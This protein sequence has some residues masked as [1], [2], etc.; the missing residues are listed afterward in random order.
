MKRIILTVVVFIAAVTGYAQ[1]MS[2]GITVGSG[3]SRMSNSGQDVVH[4][5]SC[6][7]GGTFVYSTDTHWGFAADVKYSREGYKYTYPG[8]GSY[9]GQ[10]LDTRV[11]S[12]FIRIPIR[13]IYFFN[14][15]DKGVRPKIS[16]GPSVG[17]LTGGKIRV[18]D[19][20]TNLSK[21]PV[22]DQFNA[23]DLGIQGTIGVDFR[24]A[25]DVWLRTDIAYYQGFLKQNTYGSNNMMNMNLVLN[26]G[27]TV[28]IGK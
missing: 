13:A 23:V 20:K 21:T 4:K 24:L 17:F 10:T 14:T 8:T 15:Y 7:V 25:Q 1:H 26:L 11:S 6:N 18:E 19:D 16:L 9:E 12:D 3:T 27:L 5:E 22:K 2:I 28:G